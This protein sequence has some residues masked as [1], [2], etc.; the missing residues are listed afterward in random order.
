MMNQ[1]RISDGDESLYYYQQILYTNFVKCQT[2]LDRTIYVYDVAFLQRYVL[3][4]SVCLGL[5]NISNLVW[6]GYMFRNEP[7]S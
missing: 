5:K 3:G 2:F 6:F 1:N 4:Y 7:N